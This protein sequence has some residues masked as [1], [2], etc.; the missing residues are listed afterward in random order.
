MNAGR[1]PRR[2]RG[3]E[4]SVTAEL[5]I[6]TPVAIAL[7]CLI[8][9]VGRSTTARAQV[10]GAA[11]DAARVAS[12][13]RDPRS[14]ALAA[15]ESADVTLST[16]SVRCAR[17]QVTA[18]VS[19][20]GPGGQVKVSVTC[21]IELSDLGL[22]GMSGTRTLAATSVEPIDLYRSTGS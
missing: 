12:F 16:T 8:A 13:A 2:L 19:S 5:V 20:F 14:A 10:E 21:D 9:L 3:D 11:R 1:V 18:D 7:L 22:I 15:Q 6:I 17:S 4:G